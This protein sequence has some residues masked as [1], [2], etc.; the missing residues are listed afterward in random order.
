MR[1]QGMPFGILR[2]LL[3]LGQRVLT[4]DKLDRD[5]GAKA[6]SPQYYARA[7]ALREETLNASLMLAVQMTK[8]ILF[9]SDESGDNY[10]AWKIAATLGSP[11]LWEALIYTR[12]S[13]ILNWP[14]EKWIIALCSC[15]STEAHIEY[16]RAVLDEHCTGSEPVFGCFQGAVVIGNSRGNDPIFTADGQL[17]EE[18]NSDEIVEAF[19]T[20]LIRIKP[21]RIIRLVSSNLDNLTHIIACCEPDPKCERLVASINLWDD[22]VVKGSVCSGE[23]EAD[24]QT[25]GT[26]IRD[27]DQLAIFVHDLVMNHIPFVTK[28]GMQDEAC[29][30]E[31]TIEPPQ[32]E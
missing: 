10:L 5:T 26:Y 3:D 8:N 7:E 31:W 11:D 25:R 23:R 1:A 15:A 29:T 2:E 27:I 24:I 19:N 16:I 22:Q 6:E 21:D 13:V 32:I 18:A 17:M 20:M 12:P 4:K 28:I 30:L 14:T 9:V